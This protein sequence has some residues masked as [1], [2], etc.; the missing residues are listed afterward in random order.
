MKK[1]VSFLLSTLVAVMLIASPAFATLDSTNPNQVFVSGKDVVG[2]SLPL[3]VQSITTPQEFAQAKTWGRVVRL[4]QTTS[5][6]FFDLGI[7]KNGNFFI[8]APQSSASVHAL[9]IA[10]DGTVTIPKLSK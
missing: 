10:P 1:I 5:K 9:I 2:G 3:R 8:N 7:D 6:T 4:E